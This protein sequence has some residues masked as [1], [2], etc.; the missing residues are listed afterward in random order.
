MYFNPLTSIKLLECPIA[1]RKREKK[2]AENILKAERNQEE[3]YD[4]IHSKLCPKQFVK[5][6]EEI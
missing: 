1:Y 3:Y 6:P 5:F 4:K 2:Y